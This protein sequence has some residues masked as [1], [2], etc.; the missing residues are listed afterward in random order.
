MR[1]WYTYKTFIFQYPLSEIVVIH[2]DA[3]VL[4]DVN[5]L[6]KYIKEVSVVARFFVSN[7][8]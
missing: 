2:S 7:H 6:Q 4:E 1:S 3:D 8:L 5:A